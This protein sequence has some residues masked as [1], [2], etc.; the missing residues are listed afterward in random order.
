MWRV[1][2]SGALI[3]RVSNQVEVDITYAGD[4]LVN[5]GTPTHRA[6]RMMAH[7]VPSQL[8][9]NLH[10]TLRSSR[11]E[12]TRL[13]LCPSIELYLLTADYPRGEMDHDEML[14]TL[15]APAYWAFCWASGQVLAA[16]IIENPGVF[17][18]RVVLDFGCGSGVLG[19]AAAL[20]GAR[21]VIACDN[22]R[23]A[24]DAARANAALNGTELEY[25]TDLDELAGPV[26]VVIAADVLYDR[27]NMPLLEK[28]P[29]LGRTVII[30]DSRVKDVELH[31]YRL[32]NRRAA[33]TIPDL[34][35]YR[36]FNDV[37]VYQAILG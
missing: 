19:I 34:D 32:L 10:Q 16:Y 11:L 7:P 31:G 28:L 12:Q 24:L 8:V 25:L 35:E 33:T 27:D 26:D 3:G 18:D 36:E 21:R 6:P 15:N 1:T 14:A 29:A 37:K 4:N 30:A 20:T 9:R 17:A 2:S 22:D 13:P 23:M 5:T